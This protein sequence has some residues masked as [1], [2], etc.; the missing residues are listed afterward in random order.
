MEGA[1]DIVALNEEIKNE[2]AIIDLIQSELRKVIVGQAV[3]LGPFVDM[4]SF[5]I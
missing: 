5:V 2:S 4:G 1:P 3:I